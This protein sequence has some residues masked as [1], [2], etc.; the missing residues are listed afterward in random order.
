[1]DNNKSIEVLKELW[2]YQKTEK[3]SETEIRT[4]IDY[5]IKSI[6]F[7]KEV[8]SLMNINEFPEYFEE[9]VIN[10]FNIMFLKEV[11]NESNK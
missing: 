10:A 6:C 3:Y 7:A 2:R 11:T 8:E 9:D 4:A 1:M 5:A